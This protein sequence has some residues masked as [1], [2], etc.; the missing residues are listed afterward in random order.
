MEKARIFCISKAFSFFFLKKNKQKTQ[1]ASLW[2]DFFPARIP[3][4]RLS[5]FLQKATRKRK[6][7]SEVFASVLREALLVFLFLVSE[8]LFLNLSGWH[9]K[10]TKLCNC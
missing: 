6:A 1:K 9:V 3:T 7:H 2:W 5:Q 8:E 10:P 4:G